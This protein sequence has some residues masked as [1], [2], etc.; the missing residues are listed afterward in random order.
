MLKYPL[1]I[2]NSWLKSARTC[3]RMFHYKYREGLRTQKISHALERGTWVHAFLDEY[4]QTGDWGNAEA[5][6]RKTYPEGVE[7]TDDYLL[8]LADLCD[9]IL[10]HYTEEYGE[11]DM[12]IV[13]SEVM[14]SARI[15][16][17]DWSLTGK[18]DLFF[19]QGGILRGRD[20]KTGRIPSPD[21]RLMD[22]QLYIYDFLAADN[23]LDVEIWDYDYIVPALPTNPQELKAGGLSKRKNIKAT[24]A[25]YMAA[26]KDAGY[27]PAD[28]TD[29][30][31]I[32][33]NKP[34][35]FFVRETVHRSPVVTQAILS[36][37]ESTVG[38]ISYLD[39]ATPGIWAPTGMH[40]YG[41]CNGCEYKPLCITDLHDGDRGVIIESSYTRKE[42]R[43][44]ETRGQKETQKEEEIYVNLAKR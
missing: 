5:D 34:N 23:G 33:K 11:E 22:P 28:Y 36:G 31:A 4:V 38:Q 13:D 21:Q 42:D 44:K 25:S 29:I 19:R 32:L 27:D 39:N 2:S 18:I 7:G 1:T 10:N 24:H 15:P 9:G 41:A 16:G 30:L 35:P 26:I 12:E 8:T 17:Y 14:L 3:E 6:L 37:I 43:G 40:V 20:Y